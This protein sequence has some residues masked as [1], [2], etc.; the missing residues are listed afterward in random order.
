MANVVGLY[1]NG[2]TGLMDGDLISSADAETNA[3]PFAALDTPYTLHYRVYD[4]VTGEDSG[5]DSMTNIA[6]TFPTGVVGC[7]TADGSYS[8]TPSTDATI[9]TGGNQPIYVKQTARV[10]TAAQNVTIGA[11]EWTTG[12]RVAQVGAITAVYSTGQVA[13]DWAD[14]ADASGY[15]IEYD[16]A[17]TFD[18]DPQTTTSTTSDKTITGLTDG[19]AYYFRARAWDERGYGTW[20]ATVSAQLVRYY[21]Q[22][23]AATYTPDTIRGTWDVTTS[24]VQRAMGTSK[25]GSSGTSSRSKDNAGTTRR[26]VLRCVSGALAADARVGD[27]VRQVVGLYEN[28]AALNCVTRVYAYITVGDS[29]TVRGVVVDDWQ[30]SSEWSTDA[31]TCGKA[32]G[33]ITSA[34][35]SA[36]TGDRIV[37]LIGYYTATADITTSFGRVYYGT[38]G[39]DLVNGGDPTTTAGY[40]DIS[41]AG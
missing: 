21:L 33:A 23:A 19:T 18:V 27:M 22:N 38:T 12:S 39:N 31:A 28:N 30:G 13:L 24:F 10:E 7:F 25:I 6:F 5:E 41:V 14:V 8:A 3:F 37:L 35:V 29:D 34:A 4:S 36:Q 16:T 20:S 17:A 40:I 2:T 9:V 26:L 11:L 32:S 15:V 1:E